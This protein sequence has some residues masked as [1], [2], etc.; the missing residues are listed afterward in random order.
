MSK[1]D[2]ISDDIRTLD[3]KRDTAPMFMLLAKHVDA[4]ARE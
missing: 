2:E 4:P 1:S 3:D